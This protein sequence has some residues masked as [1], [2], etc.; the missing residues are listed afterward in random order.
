VALNGLA[1]LRRVVVNPCGLKLDELRLAK[2]RITAKDN[3][4]AELRSMS[5]R[6]W[7]RVGVARGCSPPRP[8]TAAIRLRRLLRRSGNFP[9][10]LLRGV[11]PAP[12]P[13]AQSCRLAKAC[14]SLGDQTTRVH[15]H[16]R[17]VS[18]RRN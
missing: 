9:V 8:E 1:K 6:I 4:V 17:R 18:A 15:T 7:E 11:R 3:F 5:L 16:Q 2:G 10:T 14:N 13:L 12:M